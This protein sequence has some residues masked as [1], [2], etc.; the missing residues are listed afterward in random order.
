MK[1][2]AEFKALVQEVELTHDMYEKFQNDEE[3]SASLD[4]EMLVQGVNQQVR[5]TLSSFIEDN[6][7]LRQNG[8]RKGN[9]KLGIQ[10]DKIN[11]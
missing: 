10:K 7:F 5:D 3:S 6:E 4:Y 1:E 11:F 8:F 2:M 9:H